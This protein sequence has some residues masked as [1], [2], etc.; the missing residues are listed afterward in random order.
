MEQSDTGG[1]LVRTLH[2]VHGAGP[3]PTIPLMSTGTITI[4]SMVDLYVALEIEFARVRI[5][6]IF[7]KARQRIKVVL[8]DNFKTHNF[9]V[10]V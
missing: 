10:S 8:K 5:F 3:C 7:Q 1:H 4:K 9:L 2:H 6:V